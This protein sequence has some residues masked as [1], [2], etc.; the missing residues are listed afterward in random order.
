MA[1]EGISKSQRLANILFRRCLRIRSNWTVSGFVG[2][3]LIPDAS[4][5]VCHCTWGS[6]HSVLWFG[7]SNSWTLP[8][9]P[10]LP[11][12]SEELCLSNV[13]WET[14]VKMKSFIFRA[15][16]L[17]LS[18]FLRKRPWCWERLRQEERGWQRMRWLD[19]ITDLIDLILSKL[20]EMVKDREAWCAAVHR[21]AKNQSQLSDW[22]TTSQIRWGNVWLWSW[23][24]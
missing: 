8:W 7:A 18:L 21:V 9:F 24:N 23:S 12:F 19:G 16:I 11:T 1:K 10:P 14:A 17:L 3:W 20:W 4:A 22:R 2:D 13:L 15:A 5:D 6:W